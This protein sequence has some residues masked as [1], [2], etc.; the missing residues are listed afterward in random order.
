MFS[1][2][3]LFCSQF[4]GVFNKSIQQYFINPFKR[5]S[6]PFEFYSSIQQFYSS[7]ETGDLDLL[8]RLQIRSK[9]ARQM[10]SQTIQTLSRLFVIRAFFPFE[11][12]SVSDSF[13]FHSHKC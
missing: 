4:I 10:V 3:R 9:S 12:F 1:S 8:N 2:E 5:F 13:A 7:V 11:Q 6:H